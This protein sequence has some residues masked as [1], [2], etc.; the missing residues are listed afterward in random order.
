MKYNSACNCYSGYTASFIGFAPADKPAYVVNVTIQE[1]QGMHWGGVL[2]G[3]VF[4]KVMKFALQANHIAP[5]Q[6]NLR[7]Y[8]LTE[9]QLLKS[10]KAK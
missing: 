4:S 7:P 5:T 3:P 6:T 9:Q 1:P 10:S 8:L 2:A